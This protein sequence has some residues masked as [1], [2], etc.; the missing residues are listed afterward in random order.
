[1]PAL[2]VGLLLSAFWWVP[3]YAHLW[4]SSGGA[5][6][7][8]DT[9][10]GDPLLLLFP[11]LTWKRLTDLVQYRAALRPFKFEF[12]GHQLWLQIN[13][14]L[15]E[16]PFLGALLLVGSL[17]GLTVML[18]SGRWFLPFT[19]LIS[20]L[21]L[22]RDLLPQLFESTV[23]YMRFVQ[24]I[25]A[26]H[27]IISGGGL[28][29]IME[30]LARVSYHH[31]GVWLRRL[32]VA[33]ICACVVGGVLFEFD[34]ENPSR[35]SRFF[36][37][38]F[39]YRVSFEDYAQA[40]EATQV[41]AFI[42]QLSPSGR[43][44]IE[45][46]P[47]L[48]SLVGS[49]HYF[50]SFLPLQSGIATLPGLLS[51]SAFGGDLINAALAVQSRHFTL[52]RRT[53]ASEEEFAQQSLAS[54]LER[55]GLYHVEYLVS[56]SPSYLKALQ[57]LEGAEVEMLERFGPF[58]VF[59]LRNFRPFVY[60]PKH[61]PWLFVEKGGA[62]FKDMVECW[63]R[64][65]TM[66]DYPII[67]SPLPLEDLPRAE[68]AQLAGVVVSYPSGYRLRLDEY[69]AWQGKASGRVVFVGAVPDWPASLAEGQ[70]FFPDP[71]GAA[72]C[73]HLTGYLKRRESSVSAESTASSVKVRFRS[74]KQVSFDS[75]SGVIVNYSFS[76][77]WRSS[78]SQQTVFITAPSQIFVFGQGQNML[79]YRR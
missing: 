49:V 71:G 18:K 56:T 74:D 16:F 67:Y 24:H 58:G 66:F 38:R 68:R 72:A 44:A 29:W 64:H 31:A 76:P 59:R 32:T 30:R 78:R 69:K 4:V 2:L 12:L 21:L 65:P 15:S 9:A 8:K 57:A 17:T 55:L 3:F 22:P 79:E 37:K 28:L 63:Y 45:E 11:D 36:G 62:K 40:R 61:Q 48:Q 70:V 50:D 47:V 33:V 1:M 13:Q 6:G 23:Y 51:E 60:S 39:T 73:R 34:W 19:F 53:L 42:R 52:N 46:A 7:L 10:A 14:S 27:L 54:M 5:I 41:L 77:R 35:Y 26:L 20:L 25:F 43:V 75:K